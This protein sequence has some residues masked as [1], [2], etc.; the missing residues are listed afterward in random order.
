[1][2]RHGAGRLL[3]AIGF[4]IGA[5]CKECEGWGLGENGGVDFE[6]GRSTGILWEQV[7]ESIALLVP[8]FGDL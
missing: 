6:R 5:A 2:E 3:Q 7:N 8:Q 1:M 4:G